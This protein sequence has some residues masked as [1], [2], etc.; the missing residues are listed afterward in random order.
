MLSISLK[1]AL[2]KYTKLNEKRRD[3]VGVPDATEVL[4]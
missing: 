4:F 1:E 2:V 3:G